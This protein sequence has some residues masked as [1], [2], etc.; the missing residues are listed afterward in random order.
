MPV[1]RIRPG[2][3]ANRPVGAPEAI[4][5]LIGECWK[6]APEERPSFAEIT[7][8]MLS[9]DDFAFPNTDL[10]EYHRYQQKIVVHRAQL[11]GSNVMKMLHF[12]RGLGIEV[13]SIG[14]IR[15][16]SSE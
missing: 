8:R 10:D 13:D 7:K 2:K 3:K 5:N 4:W 14:G 9:S 11:R 1:D 12:L 15:P 16:D 6:E